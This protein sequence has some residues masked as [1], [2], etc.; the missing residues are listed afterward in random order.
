M[1]EYGTSG[2][3]R[4]HRDRQASDG[5]R[6]DP[7]TACPRR[8]TGRGAGRR[9]AGPAAAWLALAF[10][11]AAI[12]GCAKYNTYFNAKRAFD[13]AER[14]RDEAIRKNQDPPKPVG[15]QKTDYETAIAKAQKVFDEYPG[16]NLTDDALF[17]RAKA[18]HRLESYR[19]SIQQ[20]DLLFRNYPASEYLEESLYLQ[21]LNYLLLGAVDRSQDYLG[22][23]GRA[24]P[25]SRWQAEVNRVSGDNALAMEE[26]E[27]AAVAYRQYLDLGDKARDRDRVG[28]KL[29]ECQ[30]ELKRYGQADTTLS[31]MLAKAAPGE[32]KFKAQL[33]RG[34]VLTRAGEFEK[35]GDVLGD[36]HESAA[37]FKAEGELALAEA[38]LLAA[39]GKDEDA[40][41]LLQAMPTE[42]QTP[43]V[44][45]LAADLLGYRLLEQ[46][47]YKEAYEQFKIALT[48]IKELE[49]PDRTRLIND[50][51]RDY[52]AAELALADAK[53]ER[54]PRLKLLEANAMLFG[55]DRPAVAAALYRAAATD[56]TADSLLA[57]NA[58]YGLWVT[59]Q[60]H[61]DRPDSAALVAAELKQ[62]YPRSPQAR[63]VAAPGGGDLLDF[64]LVQR[65]AEQ[66]RNYAKLTNEE[67][68]ALEKVPEIAVVGEGAR[69]EV[70][71][72]VRR[73]MVYLSR[74]ANVHYPPPEIVIPL[75]PH[76]AQM[77]TAPA[78]AEV[79]P[80]GVQATQ[81]PQPAVGATS[82]PTPATSAVPAVPAN[83][84][85]KGEPTAEQPPVVEEKPKPKK[86][87]DANWDRLRT[88][89]P[90]SRP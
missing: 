24:F 26:W 85:S 54:V 7:A 90:G 44:K 63:E 17:L 43:R 74:R 80:A 30:W 70:G 39:R 23:L 4:E 42:W 22:Q 88:P 82:E 53:G 66:K 35:A 28:L 67:R 61:L 87:R 69:Q 50:Q 37:F 11:L 15:Q 20:F 47:E 73:R 48:M 86:N 45:A 40:A 65:E 19:M 79:A 5:R 12:G 16:H 9:L 71:M 75:G 6:H 33:L 52:L 89:A 59:Y 49:E 57:A 84:D 51:L 83:V 21:A 78:A 3:D 77:P 14:V 46:K 55:F 72:S 41:A 56:S 1:I 60:Q 38:E 31:E 10:L 25:N 58:L 2:A 76:A 34:R 29:A 64:L 8:G 36:L 68:A 62:R 13:N 32:V 18:Y 27:S 81:P